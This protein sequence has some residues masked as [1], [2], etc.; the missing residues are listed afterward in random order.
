[1]RAKE[2]GKLACARRVGGALQGAHLAVA[3]EV[4]EVHLGLLSIA[5]AKVAHQDHLHVAQRAAQET[6]VADGGAGRRARDG[7]L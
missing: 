1:M 5:V 7:I 3:H 6:D 4:G 2:A